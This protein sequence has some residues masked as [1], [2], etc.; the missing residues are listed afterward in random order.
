M[1][2]T[3]EHRCP[4]EIRCRK[5]GKLLA[6]GHIE[7]GRLELFCP[8]CKTHVVFWHMEVGL[9]SSEKKETEK[10]KELLPWP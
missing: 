6:K 5:C 10:C 7:I 2:L 9:H 1:E 8:R 3:R 4:D